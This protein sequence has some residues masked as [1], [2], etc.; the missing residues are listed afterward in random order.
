MEPGVLGFGIWNP[1]YDWI[2]NQVPLTEIGIQY[3]GFGIHVIVSRIENCLGSLPSA[4]ETFHTWFP[5]SVK[6]SVGTD[7]SRRT[8]FPNMAPNMLYV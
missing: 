1:T 8:R 7:G 5:V 2:Q 3:L 6:T 4:P